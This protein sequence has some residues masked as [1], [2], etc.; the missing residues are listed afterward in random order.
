MNINIFLDQLE[1]ENLTAPKSSMEADD[2]SVSIESNHIK[3]RNRTSIYI[4]E[5]YVY[6]KAKYKN[7]EI[8]TISC[9]YS[10]NVNFEGKTPNEDDLNQI[11]EDDVPRK[12]Y[13]HAQA[14]VWT[15]SSESGFPPIMLKNYDEAKQTADDKDEAKDDK[16]ESIASE[17]QCHEP[18]NSFGISQE[19]EQINDFLNY[20]QT[21]NF[22]DALKSIENIDLS[23]FE[24][25]TIYRYLKLF[26]PIEYHHPN[27]KKCN[28]SFWMI[29]PQLLFAAGKKVEVVTG[30]SKFP[31]IEFDSE[32]IFSYSKNKRRTISSLRLLE[33]K[34]LISHLETKIQEEIP[35][36]IMNMDIDNDYADKLSKHK[37]IS[38]EDLLRIFNVNEDSTDANITC[39]INKSF[40][41][42]AYYE[43]QT[44]PYCK[45]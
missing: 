30:K 18:Y 38:K 26:R 15:L 2:I 21:S 13:K 25:L 23:S 8:Y 32:D 10:A 20:T 3:K 12:L 29:L 41:R 37:S 22:F 7:E 5:I 42:I 45:L 16:K 24:H 27:F 6:V 31:E 43:L 11:L 33:L 17:T 9:N 35:Y 14:L 19:L 40:E 28:E 4:V 34:T 36:E 39:F 1:F 44:L